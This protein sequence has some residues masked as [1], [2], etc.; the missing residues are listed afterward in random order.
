MKIEQIDPDLA[1]ELINTMADELNTKYMTGLGTVSTQQLEEEEEDESPAY[2]RLIFVGG[3]HA[4]RM[5]AAADNLGFDSVNLSTP[6]FRVTESNV[7][8][9]AD[10]LEDALTDSFFFLKTLF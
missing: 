5:A 3:S 10:M 4:A 7:E 8:N 9:S 1:F 6:G 2:P